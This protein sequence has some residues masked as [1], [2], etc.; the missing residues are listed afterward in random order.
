MFPP[1][2]WPSALS[3]KGAFS[4]QTAID[5]VVPSRADNEL[6]STGGIAVSLGGVAV[7]LSSIRVNSR[8][9]Q[10]V[11]TGAEGRWQMVSMTMNFGRFRLSQMLACFLF[12]EKR[13]EGIF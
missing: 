7:S 11:S 8:I 10:E 13:K 6:C 5:Y 4:L 12:Q 3:R 2:I 9:A 1:F